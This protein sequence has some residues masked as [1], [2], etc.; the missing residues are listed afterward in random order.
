MDFVK[1]QL[2]ESPE[3]K[4]RKAELQCAPSVVLASATGQSHGIKGRSISQYSR[5]HHPYEHERPHFKGKSIICLDILEYKPV[6]PPRKRILLE[7]EPGIGKSTLTKQL[8]YKFAEGT[9]ASEYKLVIRVVLRSLP[10]DTTLSVE[11]LVRSCTSDVGTSLDEEDV[12]TLSQYITA[13]KGKDT[14][15]IMDG[16]DE[17]PEELQEISLVADILNGKILPQSSF[18]ITS[19]PRASVP[20]HDKIDRRI[21]V[22]GFRE[23]EIEQFI[24]KYYGESSSSVADALL[25]RLNS[26]MPRIKAMCFIPLILLMTCYVNDVLDAPP[27]TISDL[28][29][30]II[31]LTVKRHFEKNG[32]KMKICSFE[33]VLRLCPRLIKLSQLALDGVLKD[34][35]IFHNLEL[36]EDDHFGLMNCISYRSAFGGVTGSYHFLHRTVQEFLA[37]CAVKQLPAE[38]QRKFWKERLVLGYNKRGEFV[39]SDSNYEMPFLFFCGIGGLENDAVRDLLFEPLKFTNDHMFAA[40]TPLS[41]IA[42]AVAESRNEELCPRFMEYCSDADIS[43]LSPQ[44]LNSLAYLMTI[45]RHN[46][47]LS[48]SVSNQSDSFIQQ[49][50]GK[51]TYLEEV[52]IKSELILLVEI[53]EKTLLLTVDMP[54]IEEVTN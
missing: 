54:Y 45:S 29:K 17:F 43:Y 15:F 30:S 25:A 22:S 46:K 20:L 52:I 26:T 5:Y 49:I 11:D 47:R 32:V 40:W 38:E 12:S 14:L 21:E 35:I 7:G 27:D 53:C 31:C 3:L 41:E 39:L 18:I 44:Q 36:S 28:F 13:N 8:C 48:V 16:Y 51:V 50:S 37:A 19:R 24:R 23:E 34:V 10:S 33:D 2:V 1:L 9:F 42:T 6:Q 4:V